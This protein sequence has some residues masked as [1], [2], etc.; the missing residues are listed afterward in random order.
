MF[1]D[2]LANISFSPEFYN[3]YLF[4]RKGDSLNDLHELS[5]EYKIAEWG[6]FKDRMK[7]KKKILNFTFQ[8]LLNLDERKRDKFYTSFIRN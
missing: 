4:G 3:G 8:D 6:G 5:V 7:Y 1:L 2:T